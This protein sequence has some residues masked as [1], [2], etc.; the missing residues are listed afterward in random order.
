MRSHLAAALL[1]AGIAGCAQHPP[2]PA[3]LAPPLRAS[4]ELSVRLMWSSP[5]DLDLYL[6]DPTSETAYFANNPS[7]SGIQLRRDTRCA[8]ATHG[9]GPFVEEAHAP[10]A[11]PP[12]RYRVGVD[13]IDA[14]ASKTNVVNYRIVVDYGA[15]RRESAGTIRLDQFEPVVLEFELRRSEPNRPLELVQEVP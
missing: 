7:R 13:F 5:V 15:S 2:P 1:A 12:G 10:P 8:D 11:P 4:E 14:C 9:S 3:P 6:T